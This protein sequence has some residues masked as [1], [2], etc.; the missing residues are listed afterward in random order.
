VHKT[1]LL[2]LL[3]GSDR[4]RTSRSCVVQRGA[5]ADWW[6]SWPM[7]S[8]L[9]SLW[10]RDYQFLFFVLI[11]QIMDTCVFEPPF[12]GSGTTCDVHLGLIGKRVV[13]FLLVI[14][15]L[16]VARCYGWGST[17]ENRSKIGDF[18]PT[19]SVRPRISGRRGRLHQSFL[20]E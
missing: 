6:Y 11:V 10:R 3:T 17:G 1:G 13:D 14:I 18:A 5:V 20:H 7:A 15:E 8:T 9:A 16:F 12:G 4:P 19:Q 2:D